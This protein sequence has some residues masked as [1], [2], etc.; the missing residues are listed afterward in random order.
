MTVPTG[1]RMATT[2]L[3]LASGIALAVLL[4]GCS[5]SETLAPPPPQ[6]GLGCVDD[7]ARCIAERGT[8]LKS[9]MADKSKSWVRQPATPTA[10]ASGVRLWA[11]KQRKRDL[12]CEELSIARRE[13]DVAAPT[14][15]SANGSL[16]PAQI[17]RGIMLAQDVSK[18]LGNEFG[19]RCRA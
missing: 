8:V 7:S 16:T 1:T 10:Y 6:A 5:S 13:A 15:R 17:S 3:M 12:S 9:Y 4:A 19:R 11:F 14:L 18:E 2:G